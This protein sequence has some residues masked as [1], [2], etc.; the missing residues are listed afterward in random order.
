MAWLT[1]ETKPEALALEG[2][3]KARVEAA[4]DQALSPERG[5]ARPLA[6]W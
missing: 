2:R 5:A 4:A 6:T 3:I 1:T